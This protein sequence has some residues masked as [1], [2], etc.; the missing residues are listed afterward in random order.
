MKSI[1]GDKMRLWF[2]TDGKVVVQITAA[3]WPAAQQA[4]RSVQQGQQDHRR[5]ESVPRV[6]KEMPAQT[7][8]LML[9]DA[10]NIFGMMPEAF[11]PMIGGQLPPGWP[12]MPAKDA[13]LV[14]RMSVTLQP[15]RGGFDLFISAAA[16][17][18]FY[19]AFVKPVWVSEV[20]P[21]RRLRLSAKAQAASGGRVGRS[22]LCVCLRCAGLPYSSWSS[23]PRC[24]SCGPKLT[25]RQLLERPGAWCSSAR[26]AGVGR[27]AR[28]RRHSGTH[29]PARRVAGGAASAR[30][31]VSDATGRRV[32]PIVEFSRR[33]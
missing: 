20:I 17:Q 29:R 30:R 4:A 13:Q 18:E 2:G 31:G 16:A 10:V 9:I 27:G 21:A 3:D 28:R 14:P 8:F 32:A 11:R 25:D 12:K 33:G 1:L 6:R 19:K 15:Q 5:G 22:P 24:R 26:R 7:S 23:V